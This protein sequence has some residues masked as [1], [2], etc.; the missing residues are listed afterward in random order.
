LFNDVPFVFVIVLRAK[1]PSLVTNDEAAIFVIERASSVTEI[2]IVM[3]ES[4]LMNTFLVVP[5]TL[6]PYRSLERRNFGKS[7]P[8][9]WFAAAF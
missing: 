7:S 4:S 3:S 2:L 8:P 1:A 9:V 5:V 6:R